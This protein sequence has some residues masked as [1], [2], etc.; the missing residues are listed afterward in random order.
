[1]LAAT[2]SDECGVVLCSRS[3]LLTARAAVAS[4]S[5]SSTGLQPFDRH[6]LPNAGQTNR[7][8]TAGTVR[9]SMGSETPVSD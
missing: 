9:W 1:M 8:G 7:A 4:I 3:W 5:T 6:S 2:L